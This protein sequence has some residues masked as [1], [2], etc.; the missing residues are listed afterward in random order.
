[1]SDEDRI[2]LMVM[3]K[4]GKLGMQ[5]ALNTVSQVNM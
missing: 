5:Q 4:E 3:V 1:M 2:Q